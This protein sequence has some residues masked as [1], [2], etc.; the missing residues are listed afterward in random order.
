M[1]VD[2]VEVARARDSAAHRR[3]AVQQRALRV[4]WQ[5]MCREFESGGVHDECRATMAQVDACL[6]L[7]VAAWSAHQQNHQQSSGPWSQSGVSNK[8]QS[9]GQSSTSASAAASP[10]PS[11][12]SQPFISDAA[13]DSLLDDSLW[14]S[15][16]TDAH[17]DE[18]AAEA[19]SQLGTQSTSSSSSSYSSSSSST[20]SSLVELVQPSVLRNLM[21]TQGLPASVPMDEQVCEA[22]VQDIMND[23]PKFVGLS[24][25]I[26]TFICMAKIALHSRIRSHRYST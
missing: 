8:D 4:R 21:M 11:S 6:D 20:L 24:A 16:D 5:R 17:A 13:L 12:A 23:L 15:E 2:P 1:L 19:I 18:E 9:L 14:E 22:N 26:C 7:L 25:T 3:R 10:T